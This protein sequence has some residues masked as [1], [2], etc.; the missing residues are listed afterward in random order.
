SLLLMSSSV[1]PGLA[2]LLFIIGVTTGQ[3][4][5]W[6]TGGMTSGQPT[7][8]AS[9]FFAVGPGATPGPNS[10]GYYAT[11]QL[12]QPFRYGGNTYNQ[13]YL[14][15]DGYV[16]FSVPN[17][18]DEIP[19][20]HL[21]KDVIA[22]LWTDLDSDSGG[23]WTYEQ[24]TYGPL[25]NQANQEINRMFPYLYFSASWVFVSTWQ[26]VP[27]EFSGSQSASLQLVLVSDGGSQS[28]IIMNYGRIP[29]IPSRYWLAGYDFAGRDFITIPVNDTSELS[30]SSNVNIPGRYTFRLTGGIPQSLLTTT[31]TTTPPTTTTTASSFFAVG[32]G[33]TPGPNS[34]GYYATI[35]LVQPFRYGGNTYNQLN[36]SM[37]GYVAFSVPNIDDEI[38]NAHLGKDVIAPLWTDLDSDSGGRWTY[39][40]ATYGPLINQ[41]NQ[42]INRMFPYLYFSASWVFVSTWENVPLELSGF[43]SASLQLVLV[44]DG[45]SQSF[46]IMNYGRIPSIPSRYW[47][48]GYDFAGRDFITIPVN[49]TSELSSSSNVNIP[50]R[51][52]FRLTVSSFFNVGPGATPGPNSDGDY[53]RI[54]LAQ[55]FRYGG[56]TYNQFYLSMDGYVAFSVPNI[57]DEIPNVHLGKD[58]IAP[59]WTDLDS[60]SGGRWTYEQAT[61]GPLINQAN[62]E[63]NRMFPNIYFSA[64]WV[65]VSTWENVPLELSGSQASLQL[66]LASDGGS[67]S[68]I[69]MNYGRI[70]SIYSSYWLAGY[71][72]ANSN[73]VNIPVNDTSKLSSS[74]NVNIPGRFA[75]PLTG[76][77]STQ[78][79]TQ[80]EVCTSLNGTYGCACGNASTPSPNFD[81]IETCSGGAGSLS[82]SRCQ[83]FES[84]Y[85]AD[86]LHLNDQTCK[87]QLQND[88]LVFSFDS[89]A[90]LCGTTLEN[91]RTHIIFKNSVGTIDGLSVITRTGGLNIAFSCVYPIIQS[92]SMR[93]AVEAIGSTVSRSLSTEGSYQISM[94]PYTDDTF[95]VPLI[96]NVTLEVNHQ[97]YIA[98]NVNTF[99]SSQIALVL[100]NCWATPVNQSDYNIRWDLII[101]ECPNYNDD[102]VAVLQNG[103]STSSR[104]S[105][106]M[107]TFTGVP[108]TKLYLHCQVHLCLVQ[109]AS[110]ALLSMDGYVAF[111][112]PKIDDEVPDPQLGKDIIAPLW[113]DLDADSGGKWTY[114][115]ATRGPLLHIAT[116]AINRM[117][118]GFHYS[119]SWV[120]VSTWE[121]VPLE[122]SSFLGATFQ[123]VLIS[124]DRDRSFMLMNYGPIAS[125]FSSSWLAGYD[126]KNTDF[127]IIP[128]NQ[129]SQLS[130]SSNVH[131]PGRW[132]FP[133]PRRS[134]GPP[135]PDIFYPF[136]HGTELD[137][138]AND[139]NSPP[140]TLQ[141]AF[142]YFETYQSTVYV[143][144]NG[145]L[146]FSK[147][148]DEPSPDSSEEIDEDIIAAL[149]TN[150]KTVRTEHVV[151]QEVTSGPLLSR[152]TQDINTMFPENNYYFSASW[153]FIATWEGMSFASNSGN[154]TFQAVLVSGT[155]GDSYIMLNYAQVHS[156]GQYW[157]AGYEAEDGSSYFIAVADTAELSSTTNVQ[158]PGRWSFPVAKSPC[159]SLN[160]VWD[161]VCTQRN[162]VY[163]CACSLYNGKPNPDT[164]DAYE[165]CSGSSGSLSVS[166]CQL[167]EAGYTADS[168]HL[169]DPS[170]KGQLQYDRLVFSYDSNGNLCGTNI[171][172]NGTNIIYKNSV[173][174]FDR[175]GVISHVGGLNIDFSCVYPLIQ[176]ISMPMAIQA[177]GSIVNKQISAEGFYQ[178]TM[179]PYPDST[180]REPYYGDVTLQVNQQLYIAVHVDQFNST[181]IALVLDRCWATPISQIDYPIY[182]DLIVNECPNPADGTVE[183]LQNGAS[184]SSYFSFKM[185]TFTGF[186]NNLIYLHCQVHLCLVDSGNCAL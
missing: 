157:R 29:S 124:D 53:A 3:T 74:S 115:Q 164:F 113:T 186:P 156:A 151:Y 43:Q 78:N 109:K 100:D 8:T 181:Q 98:V 2:A 95:S 58:V 167:F 52:T 81:A 67:Q 123:L 133:V 6:S 118:P 65:F 63:I 18:D 127:V 37:D 25:I 57:D 110:C 41:A 31:T 85:S 169:N 22:P 62:Q 68:F 102:T 125:I 72:M 120:F 175:K 150:F 77:C 145:V 73:F 136:W 66:V 166:R 10:D 27:L 36:L 184:T 9:S 49:D 32:P 137:I 144:K 86:V 173:G 159:Q 152:A 129:S 82:L 20:A 54:Q 89:N 19:N 162:G 107:F 70:P 149:W 46:I 94:I 172:N 14:S 114:E 147:P 142:H 108:S 69:I 165:T 140:I 135:V 48:A 75:F 106:R 128:V 42:E 15:M 90:N 153:L 16:A 35:Q 51:Y 161:E 148:L 50:G 97:L 163:G 24:A 87:G 130:Y 33:A 96:G 122:M 39:E 40:Q 13:L 84:G 116:E 17:T 92:I 180:F 71:N 80:N 5:T 56:N 174:T 21:G 83:L 76:H 177:N 139:G 55:P 131:I 155:A 47:L 126:V 178:V 4:S 182:W 64:S 7:T 61:Y 59:L 185:F 91:N 38:P 143:N 11:I 101:N 170:C 134:R 141:Q 93:M 79:C 105:F 1:L 26:N 179:M 160:C 104:F 34:D 60:D 111:S 88:R 44:S 119:A 30:S 112:V 146:S 12:V 171:L 45:G 103:V 99:N 154:A 28:F 168:L 183:V 117:F 176:S 23:R 158:M 132:A 121:N 138:F